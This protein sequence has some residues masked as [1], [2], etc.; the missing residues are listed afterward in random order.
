[1]GNYL[2]YLLFAVLPYVAVGTLLLVSIQRYRSETFTFSSLSSQFLENKKHFWALVPFHYGILVITLGHLAAFLTPRTILLWN[3]HP[4]RVAILEVSGLA[5]G[6]LTLVGLFAMVARRASNSKL[7]VVTSPID[8][9]L[10]AMLIVQVAL[11]VWI[12]VAHPWGSSWFA[13]SL[14]PY[15]RSLFTMSPDIS[16]VT[17]MPLIVKL[18]IINAFLVVGLF[19]FTRLVHVLVI[20]NPYLW[21]KTQV[22]RWYRGDN[23]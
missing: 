18:H 5:C 19:P 13:A 1:M 12:A 2:D 11:G 4:L 20:P 6:I 3:S 21:R 10:V 23:A 7:R 17:S 14:T 8:T 9:V 22:V 15:L 16:Y